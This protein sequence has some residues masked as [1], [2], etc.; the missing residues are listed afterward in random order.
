[1]DSK[2]NPD[3]LGKLSKSGSRTGE[4][5]LFAGN[6]SLSEVADE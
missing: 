3:S 5:Y 6:V 2:M 4:G 1:M